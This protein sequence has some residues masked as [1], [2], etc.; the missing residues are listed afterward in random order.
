MLATGRRQRSRRAAEERQS[1][2]PRRIDRGEGR[3]FSNLAGE[4]ATRSNA[5]EEE[6]GA[7]DPKSEGH[8][9]HLRKQALLGTDSFGTAQVCGL[10]AHLDICNDAEIGSRA[11][12]RD[13]RLAGRRT[14]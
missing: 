14:F 1:V 8:V 9:H 3:W 12:P 10:E 13:S 4:D 6:G 7:E 11:G 5:A 2:G